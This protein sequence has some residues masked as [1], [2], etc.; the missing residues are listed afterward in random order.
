MTEL[1]KR[2]RSAPDNLVEGGWESFSTRFPPDMHSF[3]AAL[4]PVER[5]NFVRSAVSQLMKRPRSGVGRFGYADQGKGTSAPGSKAF[6][7][8][9]PSGLS[10][11]LDSLS[12]E[13][14]S[15]FIRE[16]VRERTGAEAIEGWPPMKGFGKTYS[17]RFPPDLTKFLE[18]VDAATFIR[19]AVLEKK[20][21][22]CKRSN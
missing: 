15:D 14:R 1:R 3:L 7:V 2:S 5:N 4:T 8:R 21:E 19:S 17:V 20:N 6:S 10:E 9:F 11:F 13:K 12:P 18:T 22:D 16:A